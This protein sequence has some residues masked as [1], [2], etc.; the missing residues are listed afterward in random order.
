MDGL[1]G[2]VVCNDDDRHGVATVELVVNGVTVESKRVDLSIGESK[3][4]EFVHVVGSDAKIEL[5]LK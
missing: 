1:V 5:R 3:R 4:V 2:C